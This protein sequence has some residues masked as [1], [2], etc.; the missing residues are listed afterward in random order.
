MNN[1]LSKTR[2]NA[3][4]NL[5][6]SLEN[7][8]FGLTSTRTNAVLSNRTITLSVSLVSMYLGLIGTE[9]NAV[10]SNP[11]YHDVI[12]QFIICQRQKFWSLM[13]D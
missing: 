5:T 9:T 13:S 11:T 2:T 12:E 4:S 1:G 3:T 7:M 6:T 8:D 10:L